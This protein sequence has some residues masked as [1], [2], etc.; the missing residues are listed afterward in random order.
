MV[1]VLKGGKMKILFLLA[2]VLFLFGCA[3]TRTD[4]SERN[5]TYQNRTNI[6]NYGAERA[7]I[8]GLVIWQDENKCSK[9]SFLQFAISQNPKIDDMI[10]IVTEE[11]KNNTT[12][13]VYCKYSGLA[14]SYES[15]S[16]EEAIEWKDI[17]DSAIFIAD[18]DKEKKQV[19]E[20]SK[21]PIVWAALASITAIVMTILFATN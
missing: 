18:K 4:H 14:V 20:S 3:T 15:L 21:V 13:S 12:H 5:V 2:I 9:I 7:K 10:N 1:F 8:V 17:G 16:V 6:V 11:Y 19:V